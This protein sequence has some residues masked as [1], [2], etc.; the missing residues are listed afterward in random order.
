[1]KALTFLCV[2]WNAYENA[3]IRLQRYTLTLFHF[4][5]IHAHIVSFWND[6][7]IVRL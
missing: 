1:M 2:K 3:Y 6:K 4:A 7:K 5:T